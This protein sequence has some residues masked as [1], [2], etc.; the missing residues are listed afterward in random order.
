MPADKS[1]RRQANAAPPVTYSLEPVEHVQESADKRS[2]SPAASIAQRV[3]KLE[4][5]VDQ[6]VREQRSVAASVNGQ[7]QSFSDQAAGEQRQFRVQLDASSKQQKD[8]IADVEAEWQSFRAR[9]DRKA[10]GL[11]V[12]NLEDQEKLEDLV[13]E[14]ATLK[15][16]LQTVSNDSHAWALRAQEEILLLKEELLSENKGPRGDSPPKESGLVQRLDAFER[17]QER[18]RQ[19]VSAWRAEHG[20]TLSQ[21][22]VGHRDLSGIYEDLDRRFKG[23]A[24]GD[25]SSQHD[26]ILQR[27]EF[28]EREQER[29]RQEVSSMREATLSQVQA[30]Q[31][32]LAKDLKDLEKQLGQNQ[33]AQGDPPQNDRL[34]QKV[35]ALEREQERSRV[36]ISTTWSQF[37]VEQRHLF[38]SLKELQTKNEAQENSNVVW[39]SKVASNASQVTEVRT[40]LAETMEAAVRAAKDC[41][42]LRK[43]LAE[44]QAH[45]LQRASDVSTADHDG[46]RAAIQELQSSQVQKNVVF[47]QAITAICT[48]LDEVS[49]SLTALESL[50]Q[51]MLESRT[52]LGLHA[53][54]PP[55]R[56]SSF[57]DVFA[58]LFG[59]DLVGLHGSATSSTSSPA[60]SPPPAGAAPPEGSSTSPITSML[61]E[62]KRQGLG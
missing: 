34:L 48:D 39:R 60:M 54:G 42:A 25:A 10:G 61:E 27:M 15:R 7:L 2:A 46:V 53:G 26:Q 14:Q 30:E 38:K 57:K 1:P 55:R 40:Q 45:R 51:A 59:K 21:L 50:V 35:E 19:E 8:F 33:R 4:A 3:D 36:D 43:E 12:Q 41:G 20:T 23:L 56:S 52:D 5:L 31:R 49:N 6:I 9:L 29:C 22:Q 24:T 18:S 32:N 28:L 37:Q 13:Q 47:T 62:A 44:A 17:E 58:T 11:P 16:K